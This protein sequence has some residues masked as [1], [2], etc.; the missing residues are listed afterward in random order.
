VAYGQAIV[1]FYGPALLG[2]D[3]STIDAALALFDR[4]DVLPSEIVI[5][6]QLVPSAVRTRRQE[7][8]L[9]NLISS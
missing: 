6:L 8:L 2:H 4:D 9:G 1:T 3:V 5:W 7:S